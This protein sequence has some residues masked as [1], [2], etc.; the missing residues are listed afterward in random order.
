[1]GGTLAGDE[2]IVAE[3]SSI[4]P[5]VTESRRGRKE[6]GVRDSKEGGP[7]QSRRPVPSYL[8]A[9]E[10]GPD[11]PRRQRTESILNKVRHTLFRCADVATRGNVDTVL[12]G[13]TFLTESTRP[14]GMSLHGMVCCILLGGQNWRLR[15]CGGRRSRSYSRR[16]RCLWRASCPRR[17][18]R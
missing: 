14:S 16:S 5:K 2:D 17:L 18:L 1:M 6:Q 11:P 8:R 9:S 10:G 4:D 12:Y 3:L 15:S 7:L 13:D